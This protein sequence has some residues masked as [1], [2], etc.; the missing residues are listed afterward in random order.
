[1]LSTMAFAT[2]KAWKA[3]LIAGFLQELLAQ[4]GGC[5]RQRG[6][7]NTAS[8]ERDNRLSQQQMKVVP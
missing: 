5:L 6:V 3:L 4:L 8:F 1:M 2:L 7:T